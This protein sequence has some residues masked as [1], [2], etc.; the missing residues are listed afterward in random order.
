MHHPARVTFRGTA[1]GLVCCAIVVAFLNLY[2][3]FL[4]SRSSSSF[5]IDL[6]ADGDVL[7]FHQ[8]DFPGG[9]GASP[10]ANR[11]RKG[12][13]PRP[14]KES[15]HH[16]HADHD[17]HHASDSCMGLCQGP[18]SLQTQADYV[19][20]LIHARMKNL[21]SNAFKVEIDKNPDDRTLATPRL[22]LNISYLESVWRRSDSWVSPRKIAAPDDAAYRNL[23]SAFAAARIVRASTPTKGTQLKAMVMLDGGQWAVWKPKFLERSDVVEGGPTDG[24]DRHNGEIA[25]F[26]I[27]HLLGLDRTPFVGGRVLN[28]RSE[29]YDVADTPLR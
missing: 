21:A 15:I 25:A 13:P 2:M 1:V 6:S 10:S 5:Q 4:A 3:N 19:K 22:A 24:P 23:T 11:R 7:A 16:G 28:I 12:P 26:Y 27:G 29:L 20:S 9:G 18:G 17:G 8:F 14:Q